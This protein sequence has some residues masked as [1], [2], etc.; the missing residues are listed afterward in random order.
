MD[1][2]VWCRNDTYVYMARND[3][4]E[5]R[6]FDVQSDPSQQHNIAALHPEVTAHMFACVLADAGGAL[7]DYRALRERTALAWWE[8]YRFR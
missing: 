2:Y 8:L 5:A 6:L 4:S 1:D 7:P 3:G